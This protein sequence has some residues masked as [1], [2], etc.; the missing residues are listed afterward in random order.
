MHVYWQNFTNTCYN[1]KQTVGKCPA[2]C[3]CL[4]VFVGTV[5]VSECELRQQLTGATGASER[6][7]SASQQ[8]KQKAKSSSTITIF[9][10]HC[11]ILLSTK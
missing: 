1:N 8:R 11:S 6:A 10:K 5:R 9:F 4:S 7:A 2:V 3:V